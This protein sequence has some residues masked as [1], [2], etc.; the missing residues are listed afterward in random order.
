MANSG[1][2]TN[3]SQFFICF[4]TTPHL[5][6][7]HVVFGK[8]VEGMDV[9]KKIEN[10]GSP[11]GKTN[12]RVEIIS[13]G[14]VLDEPA[15]AP[16]KKVVEQ[17]KEKASALLIE[18]ISSTENKKKQTESKKDDYE[19]FSPTANKMDKAMED[20][21]KLVKESEK[22]AKKAEKTT[23]NVDDIQS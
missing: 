11:S 10:V 1:P 14:E 17:P 18:E 7:K 5:N 6:N 8:V 21:Q 9:L 15:A 16:A 13:C 19:K 22:A 23:K 4:G 12:Q 3:G 20:V 2:G